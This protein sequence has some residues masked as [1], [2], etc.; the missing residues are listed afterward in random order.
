MRCGAEG[1][2]ITVH[3]MPVPYRCDLTLPLSHNEIIQW[4]NATTSKI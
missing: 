1:D 3:G 2:L 4:A